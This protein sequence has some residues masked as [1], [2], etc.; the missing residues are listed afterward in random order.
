MAMR[1]EIGDGGLDAHVLITYRGAKPL[2][3]GVELQELDFDA[4]DGT[5]RF[6]PQVGAM[7]LRGEPGPAFIGRPDGDAFI[8]VD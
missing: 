1:H 4:K 5:V 6:Q 3:F 7:R 8:R 2:A